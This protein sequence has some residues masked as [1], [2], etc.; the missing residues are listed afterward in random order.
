MTTKNHPGV[1]VPPPL[2][3]IFFFLL[4]L[5]LQKWWPL[6]RDLLNT[7]TAHIVGWLFIT[8]S[9]VVC[10]LSLHRFIRSKNTVVT[11]KPATSL[12]TTGIYAFTRNPMYLSLL[13]LYS[14]LSIFKG[15]WWTFILLPPIILVV[16]SYVIQQE[17]VYLR[18]A[19]GSAYEAYQQKVRRWI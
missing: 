4:S 7:K 15:N 18:Q 16:Q 9:C 5:V 6:N 17:E 12:Q 13:L 8:L 14:G 1:Y 10:I 11:I 19:F 3:Y 2:I